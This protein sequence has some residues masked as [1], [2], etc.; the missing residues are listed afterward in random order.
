MAEYPK[1]LDEDW[2]AL[3]DNTSGK[4]YYANVKTKVTQWKIPELKTKQA[5]FSLFLALSLCLSVSL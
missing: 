4:V 5:G 3:L 2:V 1:Q